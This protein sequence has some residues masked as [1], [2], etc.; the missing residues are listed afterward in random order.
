MKILKLNPVLIA[1]ALITALASCHKDKILPKNPPAKQNGIYVLNQGG[2]GPSSLTYY[3]IA[4]KTLIPDEYTTANG[5]QIGAAGNDME[6]YGSKMYIVVTNEFITGSNVVDIVDAKT[7]KLIKQ[8]S[9][10]ISSIIDFDSRQPRNIAFYKE[11]AFIANRDGTIAVMDTATLTIKKN[12]IA[13]NFVTLEGLVVANDKLYVAGYGFGLGNTVSVLD[14]TTLTRIKDLIFIPGPVGMAADAY[15]NVYAVSVFDDDFIYSYPLPP[16]YPGPFTFAGG[17]TVINSK[18][19]LVTSFSQAQPPINSINLP[20]S[21]QG[22]SVYYITS[23]NKVAVYN[24]K[25]QTPVTASFI[26]DGTSFNYPNSIA[27]N[28]ATGEV[29]IG[30]DAKDF[31]SKGTL[32]A[33]DKTGKLEYKITTGVNPVKI[34]LLNN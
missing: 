31:V 25:T 26:T 32:Y 2:N 10:A 8:V 19:D 30:D 3:N 9:F 13:S 17:M 33:F 24:S 29:F 4:S 22:D 23:N 28:H 7:S 18:T 34:L 15:G 11:N 20:I 1:L 27:V 12:I 5:T 14:L 6:I 21:V 16:N